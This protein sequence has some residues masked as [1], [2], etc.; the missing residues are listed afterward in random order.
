[1]FVLLVV[2]DFESGRT[3]CQGEKLPALARPHRPATMCRVTA[4][5]TGLDSE[6]TLTDQPLSV[7]T[8]P[9]EPRRNIM[10]V[11]VDLLKCV[12]TMGMNG[13]KQREVES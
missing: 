4:A 1:M 10:R 13:I 11:L 9:R 5:V 12:Y 8:G 6:S 3:R 7:L 2:V